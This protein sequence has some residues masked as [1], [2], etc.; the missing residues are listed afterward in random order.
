MAAAKQKNAAIGSARDV[1]FATHSEWTGWSPK[2]SAA[3]AACSDLRRAPFASAAAP[4]RIGGRSSVHASAYAIV[5]TLEWITTLETWYTKVSKP[6]ILWFARKESVTIGRHESC[7]HP[8]GRRRK[9][10]F[11][12][13]SCVAMSLNVTF[14]STTSGF[15]P[16]A[17]LSS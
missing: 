10:S 8:P 4:A 15:P 11:P 16:T 9:M 17:T 7:V 12:Q 13:K 1:M 3:A 14:G 6:P 2:R 5:A